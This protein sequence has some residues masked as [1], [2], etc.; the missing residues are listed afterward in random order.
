MRERFGVNA[1]TM[2]P[3]G[4]QGELYLIG[5]CK[6]NE[7]TLRTNHNSMTRDTS[8]A[9]F[10]FRVQLRCCDIDVF[11]MLNILSH[12]KNVAPSLLRAQLKDFISV[13]PAIATRGYSWPSLRLLSGTIV[14]SRRCCR[15]ITIGTKR[16]YSEHYTQSSLSNSSV[17]VFQKQ[18]HVSE[19]D[20]SQSKW[21]KNCKAQ[22]FFKKKIV[23]GMVLNVGW[24]S[25]Y[26]STIYF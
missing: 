22:T 18:S 16:Y 8:C 19:P 10:L 13:C 7:E 9:Y 14:S 23:D 15:A 1:M 11:K 21:E 25:S 3:T 20:N 17:D 4:L 26:K 6:D 24:C 5:D 2:W 12:C